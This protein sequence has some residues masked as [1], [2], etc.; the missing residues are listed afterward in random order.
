MKNSFYLLQIILS[1]CY[2]IAYFGLLCLWRF[3]VLLGGE[4]NLMENYGCLEAIFFLFFLL[5]L[6]WWWGMVKEH[7]IFLCIL[8]S[9]QFFVCLFISLLL[10]FRV[11]QTN[12]HSHS[13]PHSFCIQETLTCS[14]PTRKSTTKNWVWNKKKI[15]T[16]VFL[17][18]A[19]RF[20]HIQSLLFS[21]NF[22]CC[23]VFTRVFPS[24]SSCLLFLKKWKWSWKKFKKIINVVR[25]MHRIELQNLKW[26]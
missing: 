8:I 20:P 6:I 17:F 19:L 5:L 26:F 1:S 24:Q 23:A 12:I 16:P 9:L 4:L 2:F 7:D 3:S 18:F 21:P 15:S 11:K 14:Q 10:D 13:L 25:R 22:C